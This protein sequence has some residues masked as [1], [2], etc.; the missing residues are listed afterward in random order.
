ME[1]WPVYQIR[2]Q[3]EKVAP[4]SGDSK[5]KETF[6][7]KAKKK[8]GC[9]TILPTV[10]STAAPEQSAINGISFRNVVP[11]RF[12]DSGTNCFGQGFERVW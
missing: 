11:T 8:F 6:A 5:Q 3:G 4:K 7:Q 12:P 1:L 2:T 10:L 9:K